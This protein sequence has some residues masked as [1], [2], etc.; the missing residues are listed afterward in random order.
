MPQILPT[1]LVPGGEQSPG[2]SRQEIVPSGEKAGSTPSRLL[3]GAL[4]LFTTVLVMRSLPEIIRYLKI[5][6]M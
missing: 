2:V 3:V 4:L 6:N 5:R 1:P